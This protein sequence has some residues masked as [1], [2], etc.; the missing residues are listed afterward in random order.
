MTCGCE[1]DFLSSSVIP[2][3]A[4]RTFSNVKSAA[5]IARQPEVPNL[6]SAIRNPENRS[7][8]FHSADLEYVCIIPESG[9]SLDQNR[10]NANRFVEVSGRGQ[11]AERQIGHV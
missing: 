6:I 10:K 8:P 2:A 9:G 5:M 7:K 3:V 4:R 1:L 11:L